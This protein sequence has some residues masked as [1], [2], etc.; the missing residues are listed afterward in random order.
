MGS[1]AGDVAARAVPEDEMNLAVHEGEAIRPLGWLNVLGHD[2]RLPPVPQ[3]CSA[4]GDRDDDG[5]H[6]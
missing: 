1:Q 3:P 6:E 2:L 5:E 4:E